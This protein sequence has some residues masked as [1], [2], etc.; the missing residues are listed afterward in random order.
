[1]QFHP[2]QSRSLGAATCARTWQDKYLAYVKVCCAAMPLHLPHP[3]VTAQL[4]MSQLNK[5]YKV[6]CFGSCGMGL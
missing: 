1:M 2:N 6:S 3:V 4:V 5:N